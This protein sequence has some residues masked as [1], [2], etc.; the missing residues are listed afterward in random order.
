MSCTFTTHTLSH[1]TTL[2][3]RLRGNGM[4]AMFHRHDKHVSWHFNSMFCWFSLWCILRPIRLWKLVSCNDITTGSLPYHIP[5][6]NSSSQTWGKNSS[7]CIVCIL[8]DF[9]TLNKK[10]LNW[11]WDS[12]YHGVLFLI[13]EKCLPRIQLYRLIYIVLHVSS[14]M[15]TLHFT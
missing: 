13:K 11:S 9:Y 5:L 8:G 15:I 2:R 4:V 12:L 1:S 10:S 3:L 6:T 7:Q 14:K